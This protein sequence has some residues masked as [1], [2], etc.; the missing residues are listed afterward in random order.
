MEKAKNVDEYI[1]MQRQAIAMNPECG[2]SHYNLGVALLGLKKWG[3]CTFSKF[4]CSLFPLLLFGYTEENLADSWL[5]LAI[6]K[7]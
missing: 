4:C 5:W 3:K 1:A 2:T 6:E 7:P